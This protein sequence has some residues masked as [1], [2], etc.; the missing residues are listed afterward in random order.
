MNLSKIELLHQRARRTGAHLALVEGEQCKSLQRLVE[1]RV[2]GVHHVGHEDVRRLAAQ[3]H[4]AGD[5]V[6]GGILHDLPA[7]RGLSGEAYLGDARAGGERRADLGA[8]TVHHVQHAR[9]Q[10]V[11]DQVHQQRET[12]RRV[13]CGLDHHAIAGGK[14]RRHFPCCHQQWKVP[15]N[16]LRDHAHRFAEVIGDGVVV[17]F[18]QRAF[19]GTDAPGEVAEMVG[20]QWNV[21]IARLTDR[22]AV[23]HRL[24]VGEQFEILLDPV[25]DLVQ[26]ARP[27]G[28][29]G[30][31]PGIACGV[32]GVQ[33]PLDIRCV[34]ARNIAQF[35]A[36]DRT[37]IDEGASLHRRLPFAVDEV[38][39]AC[40]QF[41]S[42][43]GHVL[44]LVK[45]RH[46]LGRSRGAHRLRGGLTSRSL[47][48]CKGACIDLGQWRV[49]QSFFQHG[50]GKAR[51]TEGTE[52]V[53]YALRA[54]RHFLLSPCPPWSSLV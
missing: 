53:I 34:G 48:E 35:G 40:A 13:G 22:L 52:K 28:R 43:R 41:A 47:A 12:Q 6:I 1:E 18:R 27:F 29:R 51:T 46:L 9:W 5:Q 20:R 10:D 25:G 17:E 50:E 16:D 4:R 37:G 49:W 2:I 31:A 24:C 36:V 23:V 38:V 44:G 45:H 32:R 30:A 26:H 42:L 14:C 3:L 21:G 7:G 8:V 54:K 33:C 11:A 19:F 39:V 15:G